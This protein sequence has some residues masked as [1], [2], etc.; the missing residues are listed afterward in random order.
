M[1]PANNC[2]YSFSGEIKVLTSM[3]KQVLEGPV[4]ALNLHYDFHQVVALNIIKTNFQP[5]RYSAIESVVNNHITKSQTESIAVVD[6]ML[7]SKSVSTSS[8][9]TSSNPINT[10]SSNST[11]SNSTSSNPI[12]ST[13]SNSTSSNPINSTSSNSINTNSDPIN[14]TSTNSWDL[15]NLLNY[16]NDH[17]GL[18]L[19]IGLGLSICI[20]GCVFYFYKKT[21]IQSPPNTD[22]TLD[23]SATN[24]GSNPAPS[25]NDIPNIDSISN[26]SDFISSSSNDP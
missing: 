1:F 13:S 12:N 15:N 10:T 21:P 23:E 2:T 11:S 17:P 6:K 24:I 4:T 25:T 19:G 14:S 16:M 22:K 8:N 9:S 26:P 5:G 18:C 20:I 7:N 3:F